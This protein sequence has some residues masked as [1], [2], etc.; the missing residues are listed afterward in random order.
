MGNKILRTVL[1]R[2]AVLFS[3]DPLSEVPLRS[4]NEKRTASL[5]MTVRKCPKI[6]IS[7]SNNNGTSDKGHNRNNL[8]TK[9]KVQ[10]TKWRLSYSSNT[11]IKDNLST[12]DKVARKNGS[13]N[14]S[15]IR[16]FHCMVEKMTNFFAP[17]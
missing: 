16:R 11:P 4:P 14:V 12:K 6:I 3:E 8:R 2:E 13:Q 10:C 15:V 17:P 7:H 5:K 1:S 9:D